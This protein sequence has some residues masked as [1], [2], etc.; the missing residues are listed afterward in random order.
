MN[1]K[2]AEITSKERGKQ[3][4]SDARMIAVYFIKK[5]TTLSQSRIGQLFGDRDHSTIS[6]NVDV[7]NE[8]INTT[9]KKFMP[10]FDKCQYAIN[11]NLEGHGT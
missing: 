10:K 5:H 6:Y 2:E 1:V 4:V 3:D 9:N 11:K 7:V 8:L